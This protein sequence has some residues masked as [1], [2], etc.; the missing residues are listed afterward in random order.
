MREREATTVNPED[1]E[2]SELTEI[3]GAAFDREEEKKEGLVAYIII[4]RL[5]TP[6]EP[7][8]EGSC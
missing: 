2:E 5:P 8:K 6:K 7:R 4:H 3:T 1:R